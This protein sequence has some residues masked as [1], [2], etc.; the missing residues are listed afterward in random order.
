MSIRT[1]LLEIQMRDEQRMLHVDAAEEWAKA[2]PGSQLHGALE[3]D[4]EKAGRLFRFEQI[5]GLIQIH[6]V[7]EDRTPMMV[8]LSIDRVKGGGYRSI[9]DV[10]RVPDLREIMLEDALLELG[11]MKARYQR[12]HA[13]SSVWAEADKVRADQDAQKPKRKRG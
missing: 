10:R 12:V 4:N 13:L 11:R 3:W 1:E 7:L 8:S 5:R 2:N 6:L 9:D